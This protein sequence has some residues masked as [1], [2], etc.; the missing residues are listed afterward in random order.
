MKQKNIEILKMISTRYV[1]EKVD[2]VT[3]L[4]MLY[5]APLESKKLNTIK[6]PRINLNYNPYK[7][8]ETDEISNQIS[9]DCK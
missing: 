7:I 5:E 1:A 2:K 8:L 3:K 4:I 6:C 9:S